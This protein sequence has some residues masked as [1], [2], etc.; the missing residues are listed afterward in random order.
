M[1]GKL[2]DDRIRAVEG[3]FK[4]IIALTDTVKK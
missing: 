1:G 3:D 4:T 2:D